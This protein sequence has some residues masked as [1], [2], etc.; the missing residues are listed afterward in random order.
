MVAAG[1]QSELC[2][3]ITV[4]SRCL[5]RF[6]FRFLGGHDPTSSWHPQSIPIEWWVRLVEGRG[7][8]R[9]SNR[10]GHINN[11]SVSLLCRHQAYIKLTSGEMLQCFSETSDG[12]KSDKLSIGRTHTKLLFCIHMFRNDQPA[13][14]S[15]KLNR[16][17]SRGRATQN[18]AVGCSFILSKPETSITLWVS[19]RN[20]SCWKP[21]PSLLESITRSQ[22]SCL[23]ALPRAV[24]SWT[25]Y[26]SV[27]S[28]DPLQ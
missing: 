12:E 5:V 25:E 23:E 21:H 27:D 3:I 1:I 4:C 14:W 11:H 7:H 17:N 24:L 18:V 26:V 28:W 20:S 6:S 2:I 15:A 10:V 13:H 22:Y 9:D 19:H 8:P 16:R